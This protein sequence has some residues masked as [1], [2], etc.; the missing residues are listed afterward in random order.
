MSKT[1]QEAMHSKEMNEAA[2]Q[3]IKAESAE[4]EL[5]KDKD[6]RISERVWFEE[7]EEIMLRNG[8]LYRIPPMTFGDTREFMQYLKTVNVGEIILNFAPGQEAK[9]KKLHDILGLAF[10]VYP[11]IA[12]RNKDGNLVVDHS[13]IDRN[14][15]L[16]MAKHILEI[17]MDLNGLKK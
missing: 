17:M 15:D 9:E 12:F 7:D 13:F 3:R 5:P 4:E 10:Q 8:K 11:E 2:L 1:V 16:R 6:V 14:V